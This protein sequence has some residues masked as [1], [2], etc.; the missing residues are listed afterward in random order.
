MVS[1]KK[2]ERPFS[3]IGFTTTAR[4]SPLPFSFP[5]LS[6]ITTATVTATETET[7]GVVVQGFGSVGFRRRSWSLDLGEKEGWASI[8]FPRRTIMATST[9][10]YRSWCSASRCRSR[11]FHFSSLVFCVLWISDEFWDY[12]L[13]GSGS[14]MVSSGL[15]VVFGRSDGFLWD[16]GL[17]GCD[18]RGWVN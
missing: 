3:L 10:R 9:S 7:L 6:R 15:G 14:A 1:K 8:R 17:E 4:C 2:R 18:L 13:S 11:R 12:L 5:S 16:F